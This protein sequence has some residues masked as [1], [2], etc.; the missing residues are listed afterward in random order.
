MLEHRIQEVRK[1]DER[2]ALVELLE[3][4]RACAGAFVRR[5]E[6]YAEAIS[7]RP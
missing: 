2:E 1:A 3:E 6:R 7:R 5:S 4:H